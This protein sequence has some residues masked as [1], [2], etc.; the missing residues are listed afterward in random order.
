MF[1]NESRFFL[2]VCIAAAG[3]CAQ[4]CERKCPPGSTLQGQE[5]IKLN[6]QSNQGV[7]QAPAAGA[8]ASSDTEANQPSAQSPNAS[9]AASAGRSANKPATGA[10]AG[11]NGS[12]TPATPAGTSR[13]A[14]TKTVVDAGAAASPAADMPANACVGTEVR[15][16]P[17]TAAVVE[18]CEA[19]QWV[20]QSCAAG[21]QCIDAADG[22]KCVLP[23]DACT[24]RDGQS[25]CT[26]MGEMLACTE[27]GGAMTVATCSDSTLCKAGLAAGACANCAPGTFQCSGTQLQSCDPQGQAFGVQEQCASA[28]LCDMKAGRC[29]APACEAGAFK[30]SGDALNRCNQDQT[31]FEMSKRC[32]PGLCDAPN[33]TCRMCMAGQHKCSGSTRQECDDT[34]QKFVAAACPDTTPFCIGEGECTEC[35]L[36]NDCKPRACRTATCS[37]GKCS[38]TPDPKDRPA[39]S[40]SDM[41]KIRNLD[42]NMGGRIYVVV[43]GA[44]FFIETGEELDAYFGGAGGVQDVTAAQLNACGTVPARGT[45]FQEV[46]NPAIGH[47]GPDYKWHHIVHAEDLEANC[48]GIGSVGKVPRGGISR[49]SI[50]V[51]ADI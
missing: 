38:Y 23:V 7:A 33:Q 3:L 10:A 17:S 22:P 21:E 47:M 26:D 40:Y 42:D 36:Q 50:P 30:C 8:S 24:G 49:N 28:A 35:R 46:D 18:T 25:I 15:C 11:N 5:C 43:G 37:T 19:G 45:N 41:A 16:N 32:G 1:R 2:C 20:P 31:A 13:M 44:K 51:G 39:C 4:G 14:M 48:G 6:G 27:G 9:P 12:A 34:G 29:K